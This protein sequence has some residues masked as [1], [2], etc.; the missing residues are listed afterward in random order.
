MKL[1]VSSLKISV[2]ILPK[3]K[4]KKTQINKIRDEREYDTTNITEAQSIM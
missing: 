3:K 1:N 4:G 2:D